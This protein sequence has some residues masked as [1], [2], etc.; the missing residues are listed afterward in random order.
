MTETSVATRETLRVQPSN[1][2]H[3]GDVSHH[4]ISSAADYKLIVLPIIG[5]GFMN[6]SHA[7]NP[8]SPITYSSQVHIWFW[9][10]LFLFGV[11]LVLAA[12]SWVFGYEQ[13]KLFSGFLFV[14]VPICAV[15]WLERTNQQHPRSTERGCFHFCI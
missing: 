1:I 4:F 10:T 8:G 6:V 9:V 7:N 12:L 11:M 14:V 13:L 3:V 5:G 15:F 2:F